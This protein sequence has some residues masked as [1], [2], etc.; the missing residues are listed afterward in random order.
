MACKKNISNK[1]TNIFCLL[2]LAL[3]PHVL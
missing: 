3:L 1:Q 2:L